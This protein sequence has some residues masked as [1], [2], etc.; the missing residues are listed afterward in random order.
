MLRLARKNVI[1]QKLAAVETLGETTLILTD[2]T[3]TLTKNQLTLANAEFLDGQENLEEIENAPSGEAFDHFYRISVLCND[4]VPDNGGY[5]GDPLDAALL[6]FA[7]ELDGAKFKKVN[8]L[9]LITED[10]FDSEAMFMGTVH[11]TDKGLYIAAKGAS[12]VILEKCTHYFDQGE[13]KETGPDFTGRWIKKDKELSALGM[14]VIAFAFREEPPERL[15]ELKEK[16]DFVEKMIFL[17]LAGFIDPVR[18]EVIEPIGKCHKA[19]IKVVM[20]TGDHP[21]TALNIAKRVKITEGDGGKVFHGKDLK[22]E[23]DFSN[24]SIFARVDP[25]QKLGIVEY[26][27]DQKEIVGM[28]GDGV[29]DAP[30]L[31]KANIGIAM[32]KRGTQVAREVSDMVLKDDAFS[33]IV[34]AI[35]QGRTIF[36]N[37]KK[38]IMYQLSYHLA[39]I[40]IIASISFTMFIL[41]LYPLQLLFINLLSDVFPAL[42]LGVGKGTPAIMDK[43]PKD[44]DEP[45]ITKRDWVITVVYGVVIAVFVIAAFVFSSE[46]LNLSSEVCNNIAFFSLAFGQLL[47]TFDMRSPEE[48][49]F[50][51]QITRNHYVWMAI[52]FCTVVLIAAYLI[53]V[54]SNAL[55]FVALSSQ[56]WLIIAA[57]S[58]LMLVTNQVVKQIWKI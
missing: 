30:A 53:P 46:F 26:Y 23:H 42:A 54:L 57:T 33:S 56:A 7:R 36:E 31:K 27:Q 15:D 20:V 21:E 43:K 6:F 50:N 3:G 48:P 2:K 17:G 12:E 9:K 40:I 49:I 35:E 4:A 32:G 41:P 55:S 34:H 18:P 10:P 29:N 44:S 47:H 24:V 45:V 28:T 58:I 16:D 25:S 51:N 11:E 19:G 5:K 52:G 38:F 1:V 39:E 13:T 37:I 8:D 22:G 14:K